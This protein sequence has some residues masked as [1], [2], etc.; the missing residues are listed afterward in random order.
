M[1]HQNKMLRICFQD[2]DLLEFIL[3]LLDSLE[4]VLLITHKHTYTK[5]KLQSANLYTI[6]IKE[7]FQFS[8]FNE[9]QPYKYLLSF[10]FPFLVLSH[11]NPG[12]KRGMMM[13]KDLQK[14][15]DESYYTL[16]NLIQNEIF[17]FSLEIRNSLNNLHATNIK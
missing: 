7:I 16:I 12:L 6:H 14:M 13:T 3:N 11:K 9:L 8:S 17:Y 5:E 1:A 15:N 10:I 4:N 2:T